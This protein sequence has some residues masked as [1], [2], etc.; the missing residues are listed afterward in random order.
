MH[1]LKDDFNHND[2]GSFKVPN[3]KGHVKITVKNADGTIAKEVEGDNIVTNA[4]K[5]IIKNDY[6]GALDPSTITPLWRKWYGGILLYERTHDNL[7]PDDYYIRNSYTM[8]MTAH[9]GHDNPDDLNDDFARGFYD[10]SQ[11]VITEHSVKQVWNWGPD[12]GNIYLQSVSLCNESLGNVGT[13][14]MSQMGNFPTAF[15]SFFPFEILSTRIPSFVA[16]IDVP[17]NIIAMLDDN[18]GIWF[19]MGQ[20]GEYQNMNSRFETH[21]LTIYIK[22][23]ALR[24]VGL[25]DCATA[26][27]EFVDSFTID[28]ID[29]IYCQPA[30]AF[31]GGYLWIFSNIT[32][33][34]GTGDGDD[35]TYD[36]QHMHWWK[37]DVTNKVLVDSGTWTNQMYP[38][39]ALGPCCI[40]ARGWYNALAPVSVGTRSIFTN[41]PY[42]KDYTN[43]FQFYFPCCDNPVS[44]A[45]APAFNVVGTIAYSTLYNSFTIHST[46]NEKQYEFMNS[47]SSDTY[48]SVIVM[49]GR[50][51]NANNFI[52]C[53]ADPLWVDN[54]DVYITKACS[55][56][57]TTPYKPSSYVV[58]IGAAFNWEAPRYLVANK[59]LN[60][61][62]FNL[63]TQ[64]TKMNNQSMTIE[65]T[66]TEI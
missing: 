45:T 55:W 24:K 3:L 34:G 12:A 33:I 43:S 35:L 8:S 60:T 58:P 57:F 21:Y 54:R 18:H 31:V 63:P 65:Y 29:N 61:T 56:A 28:L 42:V 14:Y 59:F 10:T 48:P 46:Y 49:P 36:G 15:K 23:L 66:L 50:V 39:Y 19:T 32:G 4:V 7:D 52:T 41:I 26:N 53:Q 2:I 5:D 6:L 1:L 25:Y 16:G 37:I 30:Y 47:M 64:I 40:E 20:P 44:H 62:K 11:E 9:A 22:R 17:D 38:T 13:G 51:Q 27:S